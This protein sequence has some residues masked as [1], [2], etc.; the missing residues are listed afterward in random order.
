MSKKNVIA[1]DD[2]RKWISTTE[3]AALF[4]VVPQYFLRL[5]KADAFTFCLKP[6]A[7][8]TYF[9]LFSEIESAAEFRRLRG[10][11]HR[12]YQITGRL[13]RYVEKIDPQELQMMVHS[14]RF[15]CCKEAAALLGVAPMT[16]YYFVY[17]GRLPVYQTDPGKSGSKMWFSRRA[18]IQL[19]DD[20]E[21]LKCQEQRKNPKNPP[22]RERA[23][24]APSAARHLSKVRVP[25]YLLTVAEAADRLGVNRH[26]INYLRQRGR[27]RGE[28]LWQRGKKLKFWYL[29]LND[30]E[31]ILAEREERKIEREERAKEKM[32]HL[33]E[34]IPTAMPLRSSMER[35]Y[36]DIESGPEPRWACDEKP[37]W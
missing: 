27:L 25:S 31:R 11:Y 26:A 24:V 30:V 14:Q 35:R 12:K 2:T 5:A 34:T 17:R 9:F 6:G 28:K 15:V 8:L 33:L 29:S 4:Q 23:K 22:E 19:R 37:M 13:P 10:A 21:R 32:A 20:P 18:V 7:G 3:A 36:E 1:P 16:V